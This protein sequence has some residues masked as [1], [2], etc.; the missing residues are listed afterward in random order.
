MY[1][2]GAPVAPFDINTTLLFLKKKIMIIWDLRSFE[3]KNE[4]SSDQVS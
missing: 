3:E 2:G 4:Y 1:I